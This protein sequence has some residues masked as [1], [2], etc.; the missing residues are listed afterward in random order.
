MNFIF[1]GVIAAVV[2]SILFTNI[3]IKNDK[4]KNKETSINRD[5]GNFKK[6][7]TDVLHL[8][9]KFRL[10]GVGDSHAND[11]WMRLLGK[12]N[13]NYK[14][15]VAVGKLWVGG[16]SHLNGNTLTHSVSRNG[17]D[18]LRINNDGSS[19]G[20]TALYG[21]LSINDTRKNQGG[22][23]VG[24]WKNVGK[25]NIEATGN[26][27]ADGNVGVGTKTVRNPQGWNK[28]LEVKGKD[29]AKSLTSSNNVSV[30][31]Y[32]HNNWNG[33]RGVIGTETNHD[34]SIH[35]NYDKEAI[36]VK[37]NGNVGINTNNPQTKLD[38]NDTIR[39]GPSAWNRHLIIG[40]KNRE[41]VNGQQAHIFSTNG[42]LHLDSQNG[43]DM[44]LNFYTKRPVRVGTAGLLNDGH[45][46][47]NSLNVKKNTYINGMLKVNRTDANPWN[48]GWGNGVHTW[49]LKVDAS[50]DINNL[51]VRGNFNGNELNVKRI[52][53]D[54]N[55][56][57]NGEGDMLKICNKT[58]CQR[59]IH[60]FSRSTGAN[61]HSSMMTRRINGS[62]HWFGY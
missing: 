7:N 18:W 6:V 13:K 61:P 1:I 29:H 59:P 2:Y 47:T 28:V 57:I 62:N 42:N 9:N 8:G 21:N 11:D 26:I 16:V 30:G 38:V 25:G 19:P 52:C 35:T 50:A 24:A 5:T 12:D 17:G 34:L 37:T 3:I 49:D 51:G 53:F 55:L 15:G 20:R 43:H 54:N 36:R 4:K 27:F 33:A 10:S 58:N 22:L 45:A 31:I 60:L 44:Y 23:S 14:G 41:S 39:V 56:C 40:G 32:A 46:E 48:P